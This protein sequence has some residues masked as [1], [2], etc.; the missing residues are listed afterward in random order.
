MIKSVRARFRGGLF[1]PLDE[2]DLEEGAEVLLTLEDEVFQS[3]EEE[4]AAFARAIAEGMKTPF[5]DSQE[6]LDILR[7]RD[8]D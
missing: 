7:D 2:V 4:D 5:M 6:V 8:G 3:E 1:E